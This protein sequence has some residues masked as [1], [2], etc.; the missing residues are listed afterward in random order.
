MC[1]RLR[2]LY[3]KEK[4]KQLSDFIENLDSIISNPNLA[5]TES[6][7]IIALSG[8]HLKLR[9]ARF[10]LIPSWSKSID[11]K[12]STHNARIETAH[13]K[14]S[15]QTSFDK[16][17]C[18]IPVTGFYEWVTE[19]GK[20]QPYMFTRKDN[21]LIYFSGIWSRSNINDKEIYSFSIL[22]T[23][24][25]KAYAQYHHRKPIILQNEQYND[26]LQN[27]PLDIA[28]NHLN[29]EEL[30]IQAVNP[31]MNNAS[32]KDVNLIDS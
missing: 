4:L 11:L 15:F 18:L 2:L 30:D 24:P 26:W 27:E 29:T 3:S 23:A 1:A 16:R 28:N 5:P 12:Y 6:A 7:N 8:N 22:T 17:H 25:D 20:K 13:E 10:G 21:E 19:N 32:V 14:R 9:T 31:A